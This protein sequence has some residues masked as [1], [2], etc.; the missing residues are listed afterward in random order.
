MANTASAKK[1]ARASAR[2]TVRNRSVRSAV[3]TRIRRARRALADGTTEALGEL[4]TA[5]VS[6]LDRAAAKGIL[7]KNNAAR[8]KSRLMRQLN[9]AAEA[10][11]AAAQKPAKGSRR[12]T[13]P[14][15]SGG[16]VAV[17]AKSQPATAAKGQAVSAK[18]AA[19]RKRKKT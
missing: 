1:Q 2:R 17:S 6:S 8:R 16:R 10:A 12:T 9:G 7:H 5:A 4:A 19:A 3:K 13:T 14:V 18:P 11:P 15:K